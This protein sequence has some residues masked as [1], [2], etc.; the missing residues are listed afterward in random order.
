MYLKL[1]LAEMKK[2]DSCLVNPNYFPYKMDFY[3]S[4]GEGNIRTLKVT[5]EEVHDISRRYVLVYP[6]TIQLLEEEGRTRFRCL[7]NDEHT[8]ISRGILE[9]LGYTLEESEF[10]PFGIYWITLKT[11]MEKRGK[12]K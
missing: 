9:Q 5:I 7:V 1:P 10:T 8:G 2:D 11:I 3:D 6:S 4:V 12:K